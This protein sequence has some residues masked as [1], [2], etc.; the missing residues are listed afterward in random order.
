[1]SDIEVRGLAHIGIPTSDL[2]KAL[3][4]TGI[5]GSGL[6]WT[7]KGWKAITSFSWNAAES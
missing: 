4:F 1:M 6:S 2:K 5:W 7:K 3:R